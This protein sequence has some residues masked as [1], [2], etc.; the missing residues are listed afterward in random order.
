MRGPAP[1]AKRALRGLLFA[2][3][4]LAL[5]ALSH[6]SAGGELP[7]AVPLTLVLVLLTAG[8]TALLDG[9]RPRFTAATVTLGAT[10]FALHLAFHHLAAG[11]GHAG[12]SAPAGDRAGGHGAGGPALSGHAASG[13]GAGGQGMSGHVMDGHA[14]SG[15]SMDGHAM[16]G[17]AMDVPATGGHSLSGHG[18]GGS[19]AGLA[20]GPV[21]GAGAEAHAMAAMTGMTLAHALATLASVACVLYG[22]RLLRRLAALVLARLLRLVVPP[23]P[24]P[25]PRVH[26]RFPA[27]RGARFGVLL[28]RSCPRRGPPPAALA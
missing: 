6:V 21:S 5:G 27:P 2:L 23:L 24:A 18:M 1:V 13:H 14:M 25:P 15:H 9:R 19:G 11:G 26:R 10:Q 4:C 8:G 28:A 3:A 22:E 16:S 17:H 20:D 7:G 12:H